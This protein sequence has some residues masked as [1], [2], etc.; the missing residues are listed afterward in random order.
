MEQA[1]PTKSGKGALYPRNSVWHA[2][3]S[4][5]DLRGNNMNDDSRNGCRVFVV[6]DEALVSMLIQDLL[7]DSGCDIAGSASG[8]DEALRKVDS[9]DFDVAILDINLNGKES[10]AIA[11]AIATKGIPYL[12]STGYGRA[13]LPDSYRDSIV[14][15]KPFRQKEMLQALATALASVRS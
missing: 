4:Q 5:M 1:M 8:F 6:E 11:D 13:G 12:F 9:I 15:Q 7:I 14:L 10:F 2:V 3:S